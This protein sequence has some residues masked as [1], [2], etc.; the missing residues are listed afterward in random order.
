MTYNKFI[1]VIFFVVIILNSCLVSGQNRDLLRNSFIFPSAYASDQ[2]VYWFRLFNQVDKDGIIR[3]LEEFRSSGISGVNLICTGGYA[4]KVLFSCMKYQNPEWWELIPHAVKEDK[5]SDIDHGFNISAGGWTMEVGKVENI[6]QLTDEFVNPPMSYRPGAFWCWLNGNM[7]HSSI[8]RDLEEMKSKGINRAEI[9]DVAAIENPTFIPA[10]G[11]FLG[12]ESVSLIKHAI[13][14]G[15]RLKMSIGIVASSGWN[16]GGSWVKPDWASKNLYLS[17]VEVEGPRHLSIDLPFP[18]FPKGCPMKDRDTPV[19]YKD[20]SVLAVPCNAEMKIND[21]SQVVSLTSSFKDGKL[22]WD[23]PEGKWVILRFVCSNSGQHLIV[24]SPNSKGLFIDFFDPEATK[25]HLKHFMDRLGVTPENSSETGL[26]YFEFDSMELSEGIPW[27]DSFP[28]IFKERQGYEIEKYLPV[29]AGWD[30][31]NIT[32]RFRYDFKRTVSDQLIFSHYQTGTEFLKKYNAKLVSESGGPGA[33][34]WDTCPVD[35]L[36]A[37]GAVSVPRGEFWIRHRNIFLVKEISSASHI[38]G[39]RIVD[40]ESFTTWR[41][42][43]DSPFDLKKVVDRAF[44]EGLNN[45]TFHTFANTNPE[46]GL[47]GRTYHAGYD[48]NPGTTWWTKSR[49]FM[50]YLSRCCYLLQ[51]GLF[52]ADVCYYYGDQAPNFFPPFHNVPEKPRLKGLGKGYD[53]DVVNSDVI[54]NRMTVK[55]GRLVLPDGMSYAI[56]LLPDQVQMPLEVLKKLSELVKA[57]ATVVGP[58]PTTVPG[59]KNWEQENIDLNKLSGELWGASDGK[60]IFENTFGKGHVI[61]GSSADDV[62]RKKHIEPDFSYTEPSEIDYIH[63]TTDIGEIYFLRNDREESVTAVC[64]FRVKGKYPEIWDAST[65]TIYRVADYITEGRGTGLKIEL[66]A[67]G[68]VFVIFSNEKRKNI[69]V[70]TDGKQYKNKSEIP[71]PWRVNF[72]PNWGAPPTAV[73]DRLISWTESEDPGIKYFSGTATYQNSFKVGADEVKK[74]MIIDLGEVHDVAEVFINGKSA[75]ILWKKPFQT[76]ISQLL[77]TGEND[78][79]IEIVNLWVNRMTGDMLSDPEDR[80]CRTNKSYM[81]SEV[82][83]G[84]DEPFRIQ[85]AGLL[86]PVT[87]IK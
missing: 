84:G 50:D 80:Y 48:M 74:G 70:F 42:W 52:V 85:T 14:E 34:V 46:D 10:G 60:T 67:H 18:K 51:Q 27:T 62:L 53:F 28:A 13:S 21:L 47:P 57:G 83:P 64:R 25:R 58:R 9:W 63:R 44:C 15:K 37:L 19:F 81:K 45:I 1:L 35:A 38:Y 66:P 39:K 16:A 5:R 7:S 24:P 20:V 6:Q 76:D 30:I 77:K 36:K 32:E 26:D 23:V 87:L 11:A 4:G 71:G 33:P 79:K 75:G 69:S 22:N 72:P 2:R 73:F 40:A 61:W 78:L 49:P 3:Y 56:M 43:K 86:G 17:K 41:R 31:R 82:W 29:L 55:D 54:L 65:G 8:T 68:S 12:D 59:L